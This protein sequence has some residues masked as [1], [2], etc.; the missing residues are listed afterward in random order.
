M[1]AAQ[2]PFSTYFDVPNDSVTA[3]EWSLDTLVGWSP[4]TLVRLGDL[5][6]MAGRADAP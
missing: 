4:D 6:P 5:V 3:H 1:R 2:D